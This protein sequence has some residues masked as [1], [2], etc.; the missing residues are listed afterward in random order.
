VSQSATFERNLRTVL[1]K[2]ALW[3]N[4]CFSMDEQL[5]WRTEVDYERYLDKLQQVWKLL[6][7]VLSGELFH[8]RPDRSAQP[9]VILNMLVPQ[10]GSRFT[11]NY[12]RIY[13]GGPER[14]IRHEEVISRY[15]R[16]FVG[17]IVESKAPVPK[18]HIFTTGLGSLSTVRGSGVYVALNRYMITERGRQFL[19]G[20]V[21]QVPVP[22]AIRT[23]VIPVGKSQFVIK[24]CYS[25][26]QASEDEIP[27]PA[28]YRPQWFQSLANHVFDCSRFSGI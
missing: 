24:A 15:V 22:K 8:P 5:P 26:S 3:D 11:E 28:H 13:P 27:V 6:T 25:S 18:K 4:I 17:D 21:P 12:S 7:P 16:P 10:E 1:Q 20:P 23:K 19:D 9:R 2:P 14:A